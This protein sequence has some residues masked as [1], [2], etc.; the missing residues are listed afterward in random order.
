MGVDHGCIDHGLGC[1]QGCKK[2]GLVSDFLDGGI[3]LIV[4]HINP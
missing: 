4:S 1:P 2:I 3:K